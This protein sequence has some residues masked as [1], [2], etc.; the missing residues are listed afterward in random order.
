MQNVLVLNRDITQF[1]DGTVSNEKLQKKELWDAGYSDSFF[2]SKW[3]ISTAVW[4]CECTCHVWSKR[5][6]RIPTLLRLRTFLQAYYEFVVLYYSI[7]VT[8]SRTC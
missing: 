8:E 1:D 4:V 7:F 5:P 6:N 3:M 2:H